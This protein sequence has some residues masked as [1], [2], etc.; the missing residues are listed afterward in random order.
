MASVGRAVEG[1]R[2]NRRDHP[3]AVGLARGYQFAGGIEFAQGAAVRQRHE[4]M[5][6]VGIVAQRDRADHCGQCHVISDIPIRGGRANLHL[7]TG[8]TKNEQPVAPLVVGKPADRSGEPGQLDAADG[9]AIQGK[10][11]DGSA[12]GVNREQVPVA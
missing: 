3:G 7:V 10:F 8:F 5:L 6:C 12:V 11:H 1:N 9:F 2:V 4:I